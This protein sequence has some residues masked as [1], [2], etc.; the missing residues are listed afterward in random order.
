MQTD[1]TYLRTM[2]SVATPRPD[3]DR[4]HDAGAVGVGLGGLAAGL[5]AAE[6]GALVVL[7]DAGRMSD[8]AASRGGG[9]VLPGFRL[10]HGAIDAGPTHREAS[11]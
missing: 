8:G 6:A 7:P 1:A 3:V 11:R 4:R 5:H 2:P 10:A 9:Q